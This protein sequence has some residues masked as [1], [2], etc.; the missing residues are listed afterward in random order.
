M[1]T[2]NWILEFYSPFPVV[3]AVTLPILTIPIQ[4]KTPSPR[5]PGNRGSKVFKS[6][7]Y[8]WLH[9]AHPVSD[10]FNPQKMRQQLYI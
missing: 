8:R 5:P 3:H 4:T 7:I 1:N 6:L 2:G 9:P 10:I